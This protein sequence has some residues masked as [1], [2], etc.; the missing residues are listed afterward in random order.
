MFDRILN[1]SFL[2]LIEN[3]LLGLPKLIMILLMISYALKLL[4]DR[5]QMESKMD[6]LRYKKDLKKVNDI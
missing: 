2:D 1:T 4:H 6:N 3:Y 5:R